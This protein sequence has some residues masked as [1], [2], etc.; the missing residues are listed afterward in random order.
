NVHVVTEYDE[1]V[2]DLLKSGERVVLFPNHASIKD[3]SIKPQFI[4]EFWNWKTFKA[5]AERMNRPV[6]AGTLGMLTDPRHPL[7]AHFPTEAHT[8]WQWWS[9]MKMTR[10]LILD[11]TDMDY[12]PIAQIID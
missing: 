9:I 1:D 5:S 12:R 4:S 10:P 6:S 3:Q 7:F 11:S 8:H 2:V